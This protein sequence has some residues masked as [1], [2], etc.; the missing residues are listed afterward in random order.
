MEKRQVTILSTIHTRAMGTTS[1]DHRGDVQEK[2]QAVLDYNIGMKGVDVSDQLAKS[3]PMDRKMRKWYQK[4][5]FN[6][7][8]MTVVNAFC[9]HK[10]LGGTMEQCD[11][12]MALIHQ[13]LRLHR[14]RRR[15]AVT[16]QY[17]VEERRQHQLLCA[18]HMQF[19]HLLVES[20]KFRRCSECRT[21][22][23]KRKMTRFCCQLCDIGFCPGECFNNHLFR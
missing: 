7:L 18:Q 22:R 23:N 15:P 17:P 20:T 4:I 6:L 13:F 2:P 14:R 19:L 12:R 1:P 10:V 5:F 8:D 21:K 9:I 16:P 3:Y 11:F